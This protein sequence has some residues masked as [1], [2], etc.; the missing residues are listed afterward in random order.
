MFLRCYE[1]SVTFDHYLL[2]AQLFMNF[3]QVDAIRVNAIK[4]I[5][6]KKEFV[7]NLIVT[8][9]KRFCISKEYEFAW[10][11]THFYSQ[12]VLLTQDKLYGVSAARSPDSNESPLSFEIKDESA[13]SKASSH[14]KRKDIESKSKEDKKSTESKDDLDTDEDSEDEINH[15]HYQYRI[16]ISCMMSCKLMY[17]LLA[18]DE[19]QKDLKEGFISLGVQQFLSSSVSPPVM[20][21]ISDLLPV[22]Y[23]Q[24]SHHSNT[25]P[26][27][28]RAPSKTEDSEH[29]DEAQGAFLIPII[30]LSSRL[31]SEANKPTNMNQTTS[32]LNDSTFRRSQNYPQSPSST[33]TREKEKKG[34]VTAPAATNETAAFDSSQLLQQLNY[35]YYLNRNIEFLENI[36][37][38]EFTY[39]M[40]YLFHQFHIKY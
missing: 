38:K 35:S 24:R 17:C 23:S 10:R 7:V 27:P 34:D 36:E 16:C 3:C 4:R 5:M 15:Q 8:S 30:D 2:I 26:H 32:G 39:Y 6:K 20:G 28:S 1:E 29:K 37:E 18:H 19:Y 31:L 25:L 11:Y 13:E 40:T 14:K 9:L 21:E 12:Y 22:L 33:Y